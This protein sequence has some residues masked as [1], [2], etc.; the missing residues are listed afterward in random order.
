M[1]DVISIERA[2]VSTMVLPGGSAMYSLDG[3]S[4]ARVDKSIDPGD[5]KKR[6][7]N[8]NGNWVRWGDDNLFP[9]HVMR[10]LRKSTVA[11]PILNKRA[12]M[13]LGAGPTYFT[14]D[15]QNGKKV[16]VPLYIPEI[17]DWL[18]DNSIY[19]TQK[20]GV[21]DLETFYNAMP[22]FSL[23]LKR[24]KIAGLQY[25]KMINSRIG[26]PSESNNRVEHVCY[27]HNWPNPSAE[28]NEISEYKVFNPLRPLKHAHFALPLRYDTSDECLYYELAIWDG[29]RQN[30]WME[31]EQMVPTLKKH[32]FSNQAILKYHVK[33]PYD[34]WTRKY[35]EA[36]WT[37][38]K[39]K[40]KDAAV[41]EEMEKMDKFL[42]SAENSGKSFVSYYGIDPV[43][44]KAYPGFEITA[45]DNK[46]K[47]ADYLPDNSA[48]IIAI[49]FAMGYDPTGIGSDGVDKRGSG[50]SGSDKRETFS[51][52]VAT[53]G[54]NRYTSLEPLRLVTR[55]NN[56]NSIYSKVLDGRRIHWSYVDY[57]NSKTMDQTTPSERVPG[58]GDEVIK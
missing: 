58:A 19:K 35:G 12:E 21:N 3:Y 38:M 37:N 56:W 5:K 49:C 28:K 13:H 47:S 52:Q 45:I 17:E 26:K 34:Y 14:H 54:V 55:V 20:R 33:I 4:A 44:G 27:S 36:G 41:R 46:L 6:H 53:M 30:G 15:I 8:I 40:E 16:K 22:V 7:W 32:I 42:S 25:K 50:G 11:K 9:E 18:E 10:D 39:K 1:S 51:N 2:G 43:S 29:V 23:N 31:I 57:D 48:A 24:D